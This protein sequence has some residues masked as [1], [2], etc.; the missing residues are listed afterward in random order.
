MQRDFDL[1]V[2]ILGTFRDAAASTLTGQE[3]TQAV[4]ELAE[5]TLPADVVEHHL[6]ILADAGLAKKLTEGTTGQDAVW[7]ITWKGYDA[8]EQDEEDEEEEED[9]DDLDYDE[10]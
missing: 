2:T 3:V 1:V 4:Q 6:E 5:D 7:R 9:D 8:L 10:E